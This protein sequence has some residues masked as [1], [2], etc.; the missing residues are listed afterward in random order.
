[1]DDTSK[2]SSSNIVQDRAQN[3][4]LD[5]MDD[6]DDNIHTS[7][8]ST[9][10]TKQVVTQVPK[11]KLYFSYG[12]CRCESCNDNGDRPYMEEHKCKR[13]KRKE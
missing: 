6:M 13:N 7:K 3:Q 8:D 10:N 5:D 11:P 1:M 12:K 9:T 4:E 2:M